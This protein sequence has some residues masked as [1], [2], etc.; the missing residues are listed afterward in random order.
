MSPASRATTTGAKSWK[1]YVDQ[2]LQV[3]AT[4]SKYVR[5]LGA[6]LVGEK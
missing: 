3:K 6:F 2:Q 4:P 5:P 1:K